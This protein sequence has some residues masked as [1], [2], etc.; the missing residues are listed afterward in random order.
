MSSDVFGIEFEV[1]RRVAKHILRVR[2]FSNRTVAVSL[3]ECCVVRG[4]SDSEN[5]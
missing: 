2:V 5:G 1:S 3:D 4:T